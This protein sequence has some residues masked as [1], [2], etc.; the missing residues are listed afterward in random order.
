MAEIKSQETTGG[1]EEF[2]RDLVELFLEDASTQL[3][4]IRDA[5]GQSDALALARQAHELKGSCANV[6]AAKLSEI[7]LSLET[8]AEKQVLDQA[9]DILTELEEEFERVKAHLAEFLD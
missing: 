9:E 2:T 7:A 8:A 3:E 5:L 6:G 1:D 4:E